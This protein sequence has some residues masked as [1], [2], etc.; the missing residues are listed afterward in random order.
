[1]KAQDL[2]QAVYETEMEMLSDLSGIVSRSLNQLSKKTG[3]EL[4]DVTITT[5]EV[6]RMDSTFKEWQVAH[7]EIR[8]S[9]PNRVFTG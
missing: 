6:T 9:L 8:H 4:G 3:L 5:T 1:M 7:I 2:V